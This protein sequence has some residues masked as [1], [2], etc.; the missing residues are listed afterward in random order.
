M[1]ML[2]CI[3]EPTSVTPGL[4]A[5]ATLS[6]AAPAQNT[7]YNVLAATLN[8]T[9]YS[10]QVAVATTGETLQVAFVIDGQTFTGTQAAVAGTTYYAYLTPAGAIGFSTTASPAFNGTVPLSGRSVQV[11]V[12]KTTNN[13]TGTITGTAIY[14]MQ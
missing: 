8:V 5:A 10:V 4:Q 9:L 12:E 13:G 2:G 11:K 6:Q 14:G 3:F 7:Y 1:S